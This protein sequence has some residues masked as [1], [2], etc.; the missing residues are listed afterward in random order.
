MRRMGKW[1]KV[2]EEGRMEKGLN[3]LL[4]SVDKTNIEQAMFH[5]KWTCCMRSILL[6]ALG[7]KMVNPDSNSAESFRS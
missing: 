7:P 5:I 3:R 4:F 2:K 1:E 6:C